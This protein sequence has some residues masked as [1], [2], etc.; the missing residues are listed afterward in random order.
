MARPITL[1]PAKAADDYFTGRARVCRI[2]ED[3]FADDGRTQSA[4]IEAA[5]VGQDGR[6]GGNNFTAIKH[7]AVGAQVTGPSDEALLRIAEALGLDPLLPY[8]ALLLSEDATPVM[9]RALIKVVD[10]DT[11]YWT[12]VV[13]DY[14][15]HIGGNSTTG[16][17][18]E[19]IEGRCAEATERLSRHAARERVKEMLRAYWAKKAA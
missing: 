3:A 2:L 9:H 18:F 10:R 12:S 19:E 8:L 5:G 13:R 11:G 4:V 14:A 15:D 6:G 17:V 16:E 1:K 7:I